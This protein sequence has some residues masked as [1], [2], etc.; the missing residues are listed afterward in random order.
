ML[1]LLLLLF[2]PVSGFLSTGIRFLLRF[3]LLSLLLSFLTGSSILPKIFGP[4][5]LGAFISICSGLAGA[6]GV[7]GAGFGASAAG[8]VC[9]LGASVTGAGGAGA[10][11]SSFTG[12]GLGAGASCTGAAGTSGFGSSIF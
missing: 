9:G 5:S 2:P 8:A 10:G 11:C 4:A 6:A 3:S 12:A 1:V 7:A